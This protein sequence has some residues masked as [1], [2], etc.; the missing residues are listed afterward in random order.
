MGF[1]KFAYMKSALLPTATRPA[2]YVGFTVLQMN[3]IQDGPCY[4]FMAIDAFTKF[5]FHLGVD[6]NDHPETVLK[7]IYQFTENHD[8]KKM[9]DGEFTIVF[10]NYQE[11]AEQINSIIKGVHGK[12]IF[13]KSYNNY[14]SN[15]V[16]HGLRKF[17][18]NDK[19]NR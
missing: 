12:A 17:L 4:V 14:I 1:P 13:N 3:T 19:A 11:L 9:R 10:E 16:L 2:E 15:P 5:A 6:R 7:Y 18:E 8:F